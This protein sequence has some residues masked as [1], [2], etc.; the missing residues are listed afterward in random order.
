MVN[1]QEPALLMAVLWLGWSPSPLHYLLYSA[2]SQTEPRIT[3]HS[4]HLKITLVGKYN[5]TAAAFP[6]MSPC[7]FSR[8]RHL[9]QFTLLDFLLPFL[10]CHRSCFPQIVVLFTGVFY[11]FFFFYYSPIRLCINHLPY[12]F[13][14]Y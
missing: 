12:S 2:D 8:Q 3:R 11:R 9:T 4:L 10:H 13:N 14:H 5:S 7:A 6:K 1:T